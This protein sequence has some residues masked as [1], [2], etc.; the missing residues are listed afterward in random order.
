VASKIQAENAAISKAQAGQAA[1]KRTRRVRTTAAAVEKP[2]PVKK[3]GESQADRVR[4]YLTKH[5]DEKPSVVAKETG[6]DPAYV[7]DIRKAMQKKAE[8]AAAATE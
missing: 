1:A 7:W 5:P 3:A 2:A 6:V 4:A 8:K